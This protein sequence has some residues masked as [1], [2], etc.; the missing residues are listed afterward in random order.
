VALV[1]KLIEYLLYI[2][3]CGGSYRIG[4]YIGTEYVTVFPI[5]PV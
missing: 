1:I 3:S 4:T 5:N 2:Y